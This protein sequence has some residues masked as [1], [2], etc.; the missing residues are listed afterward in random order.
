MDSG[1]ALFFSHGVD[2]DA[3]AEELRSNFTWFT[4]F[5]AINHGLVTAPLVVATSVLAEGVGYQ[6]NALIN[7]FTIV[8]SFFLGAPAVS[9]LG[10]KGG[11]LLGMVLYCVYACLFALAAL[12]G[13]TAA[14]TQ[15][16]L[17]CVGSA[18]G[19]IA[20]GI[21]WTAQGSYFARTVDLLARR[22]ATERA[23]LTASLASTFAVLYLGFE[24][25][26]KMSWSVCDRLHVPI[27]L[28]ALLFTVLGVLATAAMTRAYALKCPGA[29]TKVFDRTKA[30][31]ALWRDPVLFL[32]SGVNVTFGFSAAFMNGY[33]NANYTAKE[34]GNWAVPLLAAMTALLAAVFARFFG[35]LGACLGKGPLVVVGA[36]C[37]LCIPLCIFLLGCCDG[38]GWWLLTLY[39]LQGAGRAVYE[40]TSKGI[41]AD[42]FP[43]ESVGAFANCMLQSSLSFAVCFFLGARGPL[44][45]TIISVLSILTPIGYVGAVLL[46]RRSA[47]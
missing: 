5:F 40:S 16:V 18:C 41:F 36:A 27:A 12:V 13:K 22:E 4:T 19:G 28:T 8:S 24:V 32:V 33:V 6:G 46:R 3:T 23:K 39:I 26:A 35:M 37:F 44:L 42:M 29:P 7:V 9:T 21:L 2:E 1:D 11:T 15:M 17:F 43:N 45:A 31:A 30:A 25:G 10:L 38:W 20:A 47:A 14:S 34:L